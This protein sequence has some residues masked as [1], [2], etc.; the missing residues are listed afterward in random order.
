MSKYDTLDAR[1]EL[2]QVIT[3]DL[4]VAFKKRGMTIKHNGK[5]T[6]HAPGGK[7]DIE[8]WNDT[9]HINVE[10]TKSIKSSQDREWQ[11]IKDHFEETQK[12]NSQKRC[13]VWFISP[14]TY[15]RT[16]NSMRDWN[17][18]HL[19][20]KDQKMLPISFSTFEIIIEKLKGAHKELYTVEQI[21]AFFKEWKEFLDDGRILLIMHSRLF[22][23]DDKLKTE[24]NIEEENKH[25]KTVAELIKTLLRLEDDFRENKGITHIDAIRNIIFLVFIKLYEEK[26]EYD[27]NKENRFKIES[28]KKYQEFQNQE[29]KKGA[30]H[31]LFSNIKEDHELIQAGVFS[32]SD[33]L[34]DNLEDDFVLNFF[35]EP[36]EK[37]HFYTTKIDGIGAA[38]EVLGMRT[39][40]DVKAGQ[41]FTPENVVE[42]MVR[43]AELEP[44]DVVLDPAC[45]TARFLIHA[46]ND[47]TA[48][49]SGKDKNDKIKKISKSQLYGTD[50]D[51]NVAKL[52][53]MNMYIHGDGKTNIL[54]LDGLLLYDKDEKIDVILTN[55]PL[56]DQSYLKVD[57]DDKFKLTRMEVI[58]KRNKTAEK[59]ENA[60]KKLIEI[61]SLLNDKKITSDQKKLK[62]LTKRQEQWKKK[63]IDLEAKIQSGKAEWVV[64]GKQMKGGALFIGAVKHYLKSVRNSSVPIEWRGGKLLIILDEG[65]LNT[66][67]Y[68]IVRDFIKRYFYI[69]AIISLSRDTFVPVSSTSTKTSILYAVKKEDPDA[70]QQEPIFFAHVEKVGVDTRSRVCA[71]H[72][73]DKGDN[74]LLRY[75]DFKTKVLGSYNGQKFNRQKFEEKK[76]HGGKIGD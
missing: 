25:Q 10:V 13:F 3:K 57:Y 75:F 45:G 53:K 38:Y 35:I 62:S 73:F 16:I 48:K 52:A 20:K 64:A 44:D 59:L 71:N 43:L 72:L 68:S 11:S 9:I 36:F 55:P 15:Y 27:G 21:V 33:N 41:F 50:Y 29:D 61:E 39:G 24:I 49:V 32:V 51:S 65:V 37:Y 28:F 8:M 56:G 6:S 66:K 54:A 40:K 42:F 58:P 17:F 7:S 23:D 60:K 46:M 67:D 5:S 2:E 18:A 14:E 76:F 70:A 22:S 4:E 63:I 69:K 12:E 19:D 74:I 34:A 26:R 31:L 30:I 1:T 47:M